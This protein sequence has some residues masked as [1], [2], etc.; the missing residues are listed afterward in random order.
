MSRTTR[1]G[2]GGVFLDGDVLTRTDVNPT[3]KLVYAYA[4]KYVVTDDR[5]RDGGLEVGQ[6]WLRTRQR[7]AAG[8]RP[9]VD[10]AIGESHGAVE[11]A[12]ASLL[13]LGLLAIAHRP[14]MSERRAGRTTVY[15]VVAYAPANVVRSLMRIPDTDS[16]QNGDSHTPQNEDSHSPQNGG[17]DDPQNGGCDSPQN[18]GCLYEGSLVRRDEVEAAAAAARTDEASV[19]AVVATVNELMN[20]SWSVAVLR[21]RVRA[22]ITAHP[23]L[24]LADHRRII[25]RLLDTPP[26]DR[27]WRG[28]F[29]PNLVYGDLEQFER[30]I[31]DA[32]TPSTASAGQGTQ[33]D[34]LEPWER[35]ALQRFA[36]SHEPAFLDP[37]TERGSAAARAKAAAAR[38]VVAA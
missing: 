12:I 9:G 32:G 31:A 38:Q 3:A 35:D 1:H 11:R 34:G 29:R 24:T 6:V 25:Q 19:E 17:C 36:N 2:I 4:C 10:T 8:E 26:A 23:E 33:T 28:T 5:Q 16:P 30:C 37:I 20:G 15:W 21:D 13:E 22:A 7:D 27:W 18:G 14:T